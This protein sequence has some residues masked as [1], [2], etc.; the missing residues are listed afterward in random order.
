MNRH[1]AGIA[2]SAAIKKLLLEYGV[3]IPVT[4]LPSGISLKNFEHVKPHQE[5]Y[6]Y[7]ITFGRVGSEKN[8]IF[9]LDAFTRLAP[10]F[11]DLHFMI[12]GDGPYFE[13]LTALVA[14]RGLGHRIHLP[15][16]LRHP[17]LF[18]IVKGAHVFLSAS[19]TETQ[20]LTTLEAL[21]CGTPAVAVQGPGVEDTL[22][23]DRGGYLVP[24]DLEKFCE[25]VALL[26]TDK[27]VREAKS[28]EAVGR[29]E[30]FSIESCTDRLLE[31]YQEKN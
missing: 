6:S 18:P 2:P 17:E 31:M 9:L 4:V 30:D 19:V 15:G 25:K 28:K 1:D 8:L 22:E 20:G 27:T 24:Q 3:N 29:A 5:A 14:D 23:G 26:L 7:L 13:E 11:P 10:Q 21:A 12:V 16:M